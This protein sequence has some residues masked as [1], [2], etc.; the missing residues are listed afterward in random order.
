MI[1]IVVDD[2]EP[3]YIIGLLERWGVQLK[4]KRLKVGDYIISDIGIERKAIRDFYHSI[5]DKRL[6]DQVKRLTSAYERTLFILEGD[7]D[8]ELPSINPN[9]I[10]GGLVAVTVDF[11]TKILYS[12]NMEET[13][14]ILNIIWK[15]SLKKY[16]PIITR[17]KPRFLSP[18]ERLVYILEGFP[19]VGGKLAENILYHYRTLKNF[20]NTTLSELMS[21]EGIG[22][23]KAREIYELLNLDFRKIKE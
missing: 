13:A 1:M 4:I 2:R 12:R 7:L 11:D 17:Y 14:K 15:R 19:G 16:K 10:L 9:I 21:I 8:K 6:F 22:D 3:Q 23:K 5:I 18:K 20:A